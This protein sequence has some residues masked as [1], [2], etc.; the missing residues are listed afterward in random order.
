MKR[1]SASCISA[2]IAYQDESYVCRRRACPSVNEEG[3]DES[4]PGVDCG[5]GGGKK[6]SVWEFC[7]Y[8]DAGMVLNRTRTTYI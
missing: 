1:V 3:K 7:G 5:G 2:T 4:Y 8:S 6:R